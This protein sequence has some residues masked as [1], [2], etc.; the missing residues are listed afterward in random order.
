MRA[1]R[2]IGLARRCALVVLLALA[3]AAAGSPAAAIGVT[4]APA[5]QATWARTDQPVASG[6]AQRTWMWGPG[7]DGA[8][9]T[10]PYADSPGGAR[11]VQ[12]F[13]K[14][15]MEITHPGGDPN[16]VW[17]ITNGLLAE[18]LITGNM[19]VGDN[20]FQPRGPAQVNLAGDPNDPNGPTYATFNPLMN[21]GAIPNGWVITQIVNR[22]GTVGSDGSLSQYNVTAMDVGAPTHHNVASVFWAFMNSSGPVSQ[23][24]QTVTAPLFQNPFYAT[25]YPLTEAYWTNVLVGGV[26][27]QVLVQCFE[28]RCLTYTPSNPAGWQVEAGNVGRHYFT[29]RY[30]TAGTPPP[31]PSGLHVSGNQILDA[32]GNVVRLHGVNRSGTEYACIQGYGFSD[33][34]PVDPQSVFDAMVPWKI[35]AVRIPLNEDCWLGINGAPAAY[36][37]ANYQNAIKTLVAEAEADGIYPILELHWSAPGTTQA[38]GQN[39]MPDADHSVTF[40]TQVA[41][42]FKGDGRVVFEPFNEPYPDGNQDTATAWSCWKNGGGSCSEGYS[43][44]GM[45]TLVT[46]IRN[47][48]ASNLVLLGGV[49][50]SNSLSQ[51]QSY[52][53]S[54]PAHNLGAAWHVYDFN[55]C[56]TVTCFN[57]QAAPVAAAVPVVMTEVGSQNGGTF[58]TTVLNWDDS[59]GVSYLAWTWDTWG[60]WEALITNLN[61]TPNSGDGQ[62]YKSYLTSHY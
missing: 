14:S 15:R 38:T 33:E 45:Q 10:E 1:W 37:G 48:G 6:A 32:S 46:A 53:P 17:Y 35:N 54:D 41:S 20:A 2:G 42:T 13:D 39:P 28:R 21:N 22:A 31:G 18:E 29:W 16:S 27:K 11:T 12:Y 5:F 58:L 9:M 8:P 60:G 43:V 19:Q 61:G 55:V 26:S 47:A 36:S 56:D 62:I 51:W 52:A 7:P 4:T 23:N 49:E 30:G 24:G 50:Y 25:G 3:A 57:T 44:A 34:G 59:H 40:W